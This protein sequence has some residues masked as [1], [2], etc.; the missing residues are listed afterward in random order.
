M[1]PFPPRAVFTPSE[2]G[3]F[4]ADFVTEDPVERMQDSHSLSARVGWMAAV[5]IYS[6]SDV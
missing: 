3:L 6:P 4:T 2:A 5:Y 1:G